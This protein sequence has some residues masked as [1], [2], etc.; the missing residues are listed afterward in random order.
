MRRREQR[1]SDPQPEVRKF[2]E[3][4]LRKKISFLCFKSKREN[5]GKQ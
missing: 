4:L 2:T 5:K 3:R 1:P